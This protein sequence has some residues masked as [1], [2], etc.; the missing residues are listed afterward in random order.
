[1]AAY[2]ACYVVF[3]L[4]PVAGPNYAFPHP[5]GPVRDTWS[6]EAVYAVLGSGSSV[7]TAFPSSHVAAAVAAMLGL[8]SE[9]KPLAWALAIPVGLLV[10]S[11]V[12]C[13][14]HYGIDALAGIAVA[15][16]AMIAGHLV[17]RDSTDTAPRLAF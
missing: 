1:M 14:M 10:V 15:V 6:A 8:W 7:G 3:L 17:G 9:W 12:Y 13:Q 16:A 5:T 11:T 4:F 2:V